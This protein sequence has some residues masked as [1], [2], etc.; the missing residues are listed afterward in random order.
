M[1]E[2]DNLDIAI[3]GKLDELN[4]TIE[5][6]NCDKDYEGARRGLSQLRLLGE[7]RNML[8]DLFYEGK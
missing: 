8:K 6:P 3:L 4:H 7:L 5:V 1:M 2:V